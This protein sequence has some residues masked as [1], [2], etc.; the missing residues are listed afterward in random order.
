MSTA[1]G[2]RNVLLLA[3]VFV[4]GVGGG[5]ALAYYYL[6]K[7][8]S[9]HGEPQPGLRPAS[10]ANRVAARGRLEPERGVI[11][12]AAPG[13]DIVQLLKIR[14]GDPV[15]KDQ[16]LA[17]LGSRKLRQIERDLADAQLK[18][19]EDR[20]QKS[21]EHLTAARKESEAQI[22]QLEKQGPLDMQIQE[23]KIQVLERQFK[24]AEELLMRMRRAGNYPQQEIDQQELLRVQAEQ[25]LAGARAVL[26]KIKDA[27]AASIQAAEAKREV[28][29]SD[30]QR[31]QS[32][33]PLGSLQKSV[34][35]A[36]ARVD[37]TAVRSPVKGKVLKVLVR[38]GEM[39][40]TQ[41]VFQVADTGAM[42]AV[43][44]VYETD[45]KAVREWFRNNPRVEAEVE[46]RFPGTSASKFRGQVV[47]VGDVVMKNSTFS[48][49]P[50]QD[51]DRRIVE[52]RI[53]LNPE[54]QKEAA[55]Y[56]NMQVD[57][58]ILD[59]QSQKPD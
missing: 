40:G 25:E 59:P 13:P 44:E 49:D 57:V 20:R 42:V 32:E 51:V 1:N 56:I 39:V 6:A 36:G 31:A 35:L 26:A 47:S 11:N 2:S 52:V 27:G 38:E 15:E 34:E 17:V 30:M 22:R 12:L 19:A 14:D 29:V 4:A 3:V 7:P 10:A 43:A 5:A 33:I 16:E 58:T 41:P 18:E 21:I 55:E 53:R 37:Q 50:R 9:G 8:F 23:T 54:H 45:V 48:V 24:T 46:L 28:T